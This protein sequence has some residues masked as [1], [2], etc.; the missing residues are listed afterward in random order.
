MPVLECSRCNELYYSAHGSTELSC[1]V[2]DCPVWRVFEDE[3]SFHRVSEL[4]RTMQ[5]GDHAA[6]VYTE[7]EQAADFCVEYLRAGAENGEELV[8]AV[9]KPLRVAIE[10]RLS[11]E[12]TAALRISEPEEVYAD[13]DAERVANRYLDIIRALERPVRTLSAIDAVSASSI[14]LAEWRRYERRVHELI[15]DLGV[16][17]LCAYDGRSLPIGFPPVAVESHPLLSRNADELRRNPD[18]QYQAA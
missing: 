1:D 18:F 9:A 11:P 6:V 7:A 17:A 2:C 13:F 8:M 12:E 10:S 16:T 15:L 3:V 5:R 14:G 4:I